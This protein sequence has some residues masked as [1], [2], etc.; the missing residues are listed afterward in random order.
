MK[1]YSYKTKEHFCCSI[2]KV[3]EFFSNTEIHVSFGFLSK[4]YCTSIKSPNHYFYKKNI[5]GQV[6][7]DLQME[8]GM[9]SPI[10]GFYSFK[11]K[12]QDY[13]SIVN[14]FENEILPKI[15]SFYIE[16]LNEKDDNNDYIFLVDLIDDKMNIKTWRIRQHL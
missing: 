2:K 4:Q 5:K 3:K 11:L 9:K 15:H 12:G 8:N 1:I 10:I 16:H 13:L 6:I 7:A 14:E